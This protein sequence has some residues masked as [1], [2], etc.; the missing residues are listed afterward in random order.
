MA[1]ALI[2]APAAEPVTLAEA[3]DHLRL[4][5]ADDNGYVTALITV[6]REQVEAFTRRALVTQT[7]DLSLDAFPAVIEVPLP[8]LQSVGSVTY[9]DDAGTTQTLDASKYTVDAASQP[10]RIVPAWGETWPA[11]R[12]VPNAVT[13]RFTAGYGDA[14]SDVPRPIRQAMLVAIA[15]LYEHRE[16]RVVGLSVADLDAVRRLLWPYRA[17]TF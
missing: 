14:G 2:T 12:A 9:V 4:A 7:W 8:P 15:D 1:L 16:D 6:A 11:T 3:K 10:G 13:V 17:W 5:S